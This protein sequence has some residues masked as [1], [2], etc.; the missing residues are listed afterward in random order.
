MASPFTVTRA[1]GRASFESVIRSWDES[2]RDAFSVELTGQ[3]VLHGI[4]RPKFASNR[5]DFDVAVVGFGWASQSNAG[6][7]NPTTRTRLSAEQAADAKG[8]IIAL[9]EDVDVRRKIVPFSSKIGRFLGQIE[10]QD[11]WVLLRE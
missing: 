2:P 6:N 5:N 7:P 4:W 9:F 11:S 8:L 10:F 3:Q 1:A